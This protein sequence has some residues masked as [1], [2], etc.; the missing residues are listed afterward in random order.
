MVQLI[1]PFMFQQNLTLN[2]KMFSV[3]KK[4]TLKNETTNA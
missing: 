2:F 3:I 1:L 4:Y